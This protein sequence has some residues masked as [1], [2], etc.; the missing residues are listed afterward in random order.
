MLIAVNN[1]KF[2]KR[3]ILKC[4]HYTH[5]HTHSVNCGR[6]WLIILKKSLHNVYIYQS[7]VLYDLKIGFHKR[8]PESS[9][10][11]KIKDLLKQ[12]FLFSW[13]ISCLEGN[14]IITPKADLRLE[15]K[16]W[17]SWFLWNFQIWLTQDNLATNFNKRRWIK[18][19]GKLSWSTR[20]H[21]TQDF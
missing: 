12:V 4:S 21:P 16:S 9:S 15:Y 10:K 18:V 14:Y 6:W 8:K 7:I 17:W 19:T 5:T 3:I 2:A 11:I 1:V 13:S 20:Q